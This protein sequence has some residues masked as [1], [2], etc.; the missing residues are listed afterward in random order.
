[1]ERSPVVSQTGMFPTVI[2]RDGKW[3]VAVPIAISFA[4]HEGENM[5]G[6]LKNLFSPGGSSGIRAV[7]TGHR[8]KIQLAM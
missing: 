7:P 5:L 4:K 8:Q 3:V 1:M 6:K 2:K